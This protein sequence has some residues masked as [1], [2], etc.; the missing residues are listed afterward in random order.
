VIGLQ[1]E[2][3]EKHTYGVAHQGL[4]LLGVC[5]EQRSQPIYIEVGNEETENNVFGRL[6]GI[7]RDRSRNRT[8][9]KFLLSLRKMF[10][11]VG[12]SYLLLRCAATE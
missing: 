1:I 7:Q 4:K 3:R 12:V 5:S 10:C 8:R 11:G 9:G 6:Y 2:A